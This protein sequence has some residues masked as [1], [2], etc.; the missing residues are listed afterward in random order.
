[1]NR[2]HWEHAYRRARE[3]LRTPEPLE[4]KILADLRAIKPIQPANRKANRLLSRVASAF[5][6]VAIAIV[7]LHPAQYIGATPGQLIPRQGGETGGLERFRPKALATQT[8][9]DTWHSLRIEVK[10]GNYMTLCAQWRRQQAAAATDVLPD[11]LA[12][13]ARKHCR[14]LP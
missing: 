4:T 9:M 1:M 12:A 7:L 6:A 5:T 3:Q 2:N 13:E 11:D 8:G 10:A 14:I